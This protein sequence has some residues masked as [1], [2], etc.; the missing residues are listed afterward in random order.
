MTVTEALTPFWTRGTDALAAHLGCG[1]AGLSAADAVARLE[2]YGPNADAAP[3]HASV[4]G[5]LLRRLLEPLSLILLA[6]GI[7]SAATGDG[8]GG[9][10]IVALLGLSIR[11]VNLQGGRARQAAQ[12]APRPV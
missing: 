11:P 8:I 4:A 2:R 7:V 9:G 3:K 6:A 10:V 5:A 12:G 1:I